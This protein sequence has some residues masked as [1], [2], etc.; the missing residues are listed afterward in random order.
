[1]AQAGLASLL[2]KRDVTVPIVGATKTRHLEDA[3]AAV[4][5]T[6][7]ARRLPASRRRARRSRPLL[8]S[9]S[10]SAGS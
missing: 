8:V 3:I 4:D 9:Q 7:P 1:M 6:L 2:S 10:S 5:V